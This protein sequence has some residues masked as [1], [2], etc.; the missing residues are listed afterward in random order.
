M[1]A[2]HKGCTPAPREEGCTIHD[3][4]WQKNRYELD[5][6]RKKMQHFKTKLKFFE[7]LKS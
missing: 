7:T 5:P 2:V 1:R 3:S 6:D 4:S